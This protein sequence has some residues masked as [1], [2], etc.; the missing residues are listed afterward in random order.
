[1]IE[2]NGK[3]DLLEKGLTKMKCELGELPQKLD[4]KLSFLKSVGS[5]KSRDKD[6]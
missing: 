1:M 5:H 6:H 3:N 2:M 4:Q